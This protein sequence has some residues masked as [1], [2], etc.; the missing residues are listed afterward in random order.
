MRTKEVLSNRQRA[1]RARR[2]HERTV[3]ELTAKP[4]S[5]SPYKAKSKP[6]SRK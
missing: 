5:R 1:Q 4:T 2:K 3:A 6:R